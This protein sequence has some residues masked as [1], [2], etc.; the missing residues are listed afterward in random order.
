MRLFTKLLV[1]H[2]LVGVCLPPD[3]L[4]AEDLKLA[5]YMVGSLFLRGR[6]AG[7]YAGMVWE[8]ILAEFPSI[9]G[10]SFGGYRPATVPPDEINAVLQ[11]TSAP[12][13]PC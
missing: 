4:P 10:R 1:A 3:A 9:E 6:S 7:S 12:H 13:P 8:T 2:P 11:Q 5:G